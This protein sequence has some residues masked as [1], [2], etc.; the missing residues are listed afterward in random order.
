MST[1][2]DHSGKTLRT[3][4]THTHTYIHTHTYTHTHTHTHTHTQGQIAAFEVSCI[5]SRHWSNWLRQ[6][7]KMNVFLMCLTLSLLS[8]G[9]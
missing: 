3:T 1:K 5:K 8:F 6:L 2:G 4:H 7:Q 9:V